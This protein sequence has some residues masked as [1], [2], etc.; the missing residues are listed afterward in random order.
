MFGGLVII[1]A[2]FIGGQQKDNHLFIGSLIAGISICAIA[3]VIWIRMG[4]TSHYKQKMKEHAVE[5][6]EE[7]I[8]EKDKELEEIK[9]ENMVLSSVNHKFNQR[10]SA[11]EMS[12]KALAFQATEAAN[13]A[14][15]APEFAN[16]IEQIKTMSQE[17][18][19]EIQEKLPKK[20]ALPTTKIQSIDSLFT[21]FQL[22]SSKSNIDFNLKIT[23][24]IP[25]MIEK[26]IPQNKLETLIGDHIRDAIIA[27]NFSENTYR[28]I[29]VLLGEMNDCNEL[30]VFD[31]GI[32]FQIDTLLSLGLKAITTHKDTGGSGIG[33][34]T[35]FETMKE[36]KASLIIEEKQPNK[37]DFTKSVSIRFDGKNQFVI[38][39]YR[40]KEIRERNTDDRIIIEDAN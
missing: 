28:S 37:F 36:C 13:C 16:V 20:K 3:I 18:K 33:F 21:Y 23:G 34:M 26:L 17:Y 19:N 27:I 5:L 11:L 31:S 1:C 8:Q 22:E 15:I 29:L 30:C 2:T 35:T 32:E 39:S 9:H 25:Y 12:V 10:F 6:L 38:K 24:S 14:E 40:A 4:I 7:K